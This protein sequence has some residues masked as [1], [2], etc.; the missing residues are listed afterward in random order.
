[1]HLRRS[2]KFP[3][4][5]CELARSL[6]KTVMGMAG[7]SRRKKKGAKGATKGGGQSSV[8]PGAPAQLATSSVEK[9]QVCVRSVAH[10]APWDQRAASRTRAPST[11]HIAHQ[12]SKRAV[13]MLC[14]SPAPSLSLPPLSLS[15]VRYSHFYSLAKKIMIRV[16][17]VAPNNCYTPWILKA[18][19]NQTYPEGHPLILDQSTTV[20]EMIAA[21]VA[22]YKEF[23]VAKEAYDKVQTPWAIAKDRSTKQLVNK[24]CGWVKN[25]RNVVCFFKSRPVPVTKKMISQLDAKPMEVPLTL[26]DLSIADQD[27]VMWQE[28][29]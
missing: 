22:S 24:P 17:F 26:Q 11:F 25:P 7:R 18:A 29:S 27:V 1:M 2:M 15:L 21:I 14:C 12:L 9:K 6:K 8:E 10:T 20:Q 23:D 4:F 13:V 16:K 28:R 5:F 19:E 3:N